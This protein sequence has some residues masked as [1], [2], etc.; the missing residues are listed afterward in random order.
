MPPKKKKSKKT[1]EKKMIKAVSSLMASG[2]GSL[3]EHRRPDLIQGLARGSAN[4]RLRRTFRQERIQQLGAEESRLRAETNQDFSMIP[5]IDRDISNLQDRVQ[6]LRQSNRESVPAQILINMVQQQAQQQ[7]LITGLQQQQAR[8]EEETTENLSG[9]L[10]EISRT[11]N[12]PSRPPSR[13]PSEARSPT[14]RRRRERSPSQPRERSPSPEREPQNEP[15]PSGLAQA[16]RGRGFNRPIS[17]V[18]MRTVTAVERRNIGLADDANRNQVRRRVGELGVVTTLPSGR[19]RPIRD[20][21]S[22]AVEANRLRQEQRIEEIRNLQPPP[23]E[24]IQEESG[25]ET[26]RETV[27]GRMGGAET[28]TEAE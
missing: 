20:I 11:Q 25:N 10:S 14:P 28:E 3:M 8:Q 26:E 4:K 7:N 18:D 24:P 1:K 5:A 21:I 27:V 17:N 2:T 12:P 23:I 22:D 15:P 13:E 19:P 16:R 9:L 6:Q